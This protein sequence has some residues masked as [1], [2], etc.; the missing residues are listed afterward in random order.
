MQRY[1]ECGKVECNNRTEKILKFHV[2]DLEDIFSKV[3]AHFDSYPLLTSKNLDYQDFRRVAYMI[4]DGGR[5][6]DILAI[7]ENMNSKRSFEER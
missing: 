4:R 5:E 6:A 7:K 2:T 3:I 1:F